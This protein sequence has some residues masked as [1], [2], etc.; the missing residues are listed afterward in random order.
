[1]IIWITSYPKS[2]NTW[3]RA[4]LCSLLYSRNGNFRLDELEKI[5]QFPMKNHFKDFTDD[6]FNIDEIS[7]NWLPAQ[8]KLNLDNSIKFFKTH[9]AFCKYKDYV[10]TN[11]KN[12]LATIY[13]VRDP[14]NIIT[15]LTHHYSLNFNMAKEMLFSSTR[16]LGNEASYKSKGH[17]YTVLGNWADHYNS[18]KKLDPENTLLL[19]YEDL[20]KDPKLQIL[21]IAN[22]L[23][24]Y[25][26]IYLTDK[27]I[28][29]TLISTKFEN[30]KLFEK[31]HGFYESV[32]NKITQKK[33]NFFN[34]GKENDWKKLLDSKVKLE[35]DK[36][37]S[38]ELIE[39]GYLTK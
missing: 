18:W 32:T 26:E 33:T 34:L 22:F 7:K 17:V 39:L 30:L 11:K 14:R 13:I 35:I 24:K 36:K 23:K 16:V 6:I 15:S 38:K 12:T 37:F 31:K 20:I 21:R 10:F 5:K 4:I 1:M 19:K 27:I 29:N 3:V 25:L 9:N 28:E 2:G 8:E